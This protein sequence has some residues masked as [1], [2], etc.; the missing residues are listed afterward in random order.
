MQLLNQIRSKCRLKNFSMNTE[1]SYV[2][3]A[4]R[5]ILFHGKRH[6]GQMNIR[7]VE[8]FLTNLAMVAKLSV[9]TQNQAL[10]ALLFLYK[11]VLNIEIKGVNAIRSKKPIKL[12]VV[13]S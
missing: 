1:K 11:E 9:S 4:K 5:Y 3:W 8:S 2:D 13:L 12:P 6:P 10:S 7:E